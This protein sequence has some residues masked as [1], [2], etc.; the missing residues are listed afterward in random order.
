MNLFAC[1]LLG[2][3]IICAVS[4][5]VTRSL[6]SAVIILMSYSVVMS[7]LW[8]LLEAPDLAVT[9]A[10]VGAGVTGVL[11]FLTLRRITLIDRESKSKEAGDEQDI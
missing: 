11:F 3:L 10:A 1:L 8:I 7:V 4:V 6:L 2:F 9:E 5:S